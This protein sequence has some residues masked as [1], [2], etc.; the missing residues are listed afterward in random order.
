VYHCWVPTLT[1]GS[2]ISRNMSRGTGLNPP[3]DV[4]EPSG[5]FRTCH[6][7]WPGPFGTRMTAAK[8]GRLK[9]PAKNWCQH[10]PDPS[11]ADRHVRHRIFQ[12]APRL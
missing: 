9:L 12:S 5:S 8:D 4:P 10:G 6:D 1:V 11:R 3:A 2:T 7:A